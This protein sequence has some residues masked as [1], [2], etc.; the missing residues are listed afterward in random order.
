MAIKLDWVNNTPGNFITEIYR[1]A[2]TFT[3]A[4]KPAT[5]IATLTAGEST[6]LDSTAVQGNWYYYMWATYDV[7]KT[8]VAYSAVIRTQAIEYTGPGP[9]ALTWGD[10]EYGYY[11][12][13]PYSTFPYLSTLLIN[14]G[15]QDIA[16]AVTSIAHHWQKWAYKGKVLF[17]S[18]GRALQ[19]SWD[20][21]YSYG[22]VYG[23]VDQDTIPGAP[24]G[25]ARVN[26]V[27]KIKN[28][29]GD[30]FIPRLLRGYSHDLSVMPDFATLSSSLS[31]ATK[32]EP[33]RD[34]EYDRLMMATAAATPAEFP[35]YLT[36]E[37]WRVTTQ[38]AEYDAATKMCYARGSEAYFNTDSDAYRRSAFK[39][40]AASNPTAF[41]TPI[42]LELVRS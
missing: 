23:D 35:G 15:R 21:L 31:A 19:A 28:N 13:V 25:A 30:V 1:S 29:V 5:P 9:T 16:T 14:N 41:Y 11:G 38:C 33:Y 32:A 40:Q 12:S 42:V 34:C 26:D 24:S 18:T 37:A 4:N 27:L 17:I 39:S 8:K 20:T 36:S 6:Y 7:A 3:S 22:M 2:A 10:T